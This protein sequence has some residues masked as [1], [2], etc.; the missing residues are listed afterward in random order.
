MT[1]AKEEKEKIIEVEKDKRIR[2]YRIWNGLE[3]LWYVEPQTLNR[4]FSIRCWGTDDWKE[5]SSLFIRAARF[6]T[7]ENA[8]KYAQGMKSNYLLK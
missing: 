6:W 1:K 8:E 2:I 7:L 5:K 4:F 3:W